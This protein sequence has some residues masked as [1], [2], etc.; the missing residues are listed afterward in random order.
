MFIVEN[1]SYYFDIQV[2]R[3]FAEVFT[4]TKKKNVFK[5]TR[6]VAWNVLVRQRSCLTF[7]YILIN[8][9]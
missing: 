7:F 6:E 9:Y 3:S 4:E 8:K 5:D 2:K 1:I